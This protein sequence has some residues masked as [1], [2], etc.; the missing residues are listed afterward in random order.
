VSSD[1]TSGQRE[2]RILGRALRDL[3]K[4][5]GTTQ[6]QIALQA[7][8]GDP[9]ISRVEHGELDLK[10]AT[11]QRLLAALG[12]DLRQLADAIDRA[13]REDD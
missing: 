5:A 12:A 11:L 7:G 13:Q 2:Q 4:Q 8:T 6:R 3:R 1:T 10:W 9:Y